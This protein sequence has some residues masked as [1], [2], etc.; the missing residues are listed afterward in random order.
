MQGLNPRLY[1][2]TRCNLKTWTGT[3]MVPCWIVGMKKD[4]IILRTHA[5][6]SE[7]PPG[8]VVLEA[9][10]RQHLAN[11]TGDITDPDLDFTETETADSLREEGYH[12]INEDSSNA[13]DQHHFVVVVIS[14]IKLETVRFKCRVLVSAMD[15][16]LNLD[17]EIVKG[18]VLDVSETG[19]GMTVPVK[20][21]QGQVVRMLV[22][23]PRAKIEMKGEV[24]HCTPVI[25]E[26]EI[27][28]V[29]IRLARRDEENRLQWE[30]VVKNTQGDD[31]F[32]IKEAG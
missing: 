6:K 4:S 28:R 7:L 23:A 10:G 20:L 26:Q 2:G 16:Y 31:V 1:I 13:T 25:G 19:L 27:Y 32:D 8:K 21:E 29:G 11:F 9:Y 15:I 5:A 24:R 18:A 17:G 14:Q 3:A 30:D 12:L 22:I